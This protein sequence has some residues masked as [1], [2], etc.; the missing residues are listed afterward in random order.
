MESKFKDSNK[1]IND[2]KKVL[3]SILSL[4]LAVL[5]FSGQAFAY[6]GAAALINT[7]EELNAVVDFD[8]AEIY[9]AFDEVND[10]V[11]TIEQ[12]ESI[13]YSALEANESD[14]INNVS[15]SAA[16]AMNANSADSPPFLS[17][18]LWGCLFNLL[19]MLIVGITTEF[20]SDQM[21]KSAW[22]CL[23]NTLL[24]SGGYISTY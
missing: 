10:L 20:D 16:I 14:L 9:A 21:R 3:Q 6:T 5:L 22:G 18:F 13:T 23:I 8:E 7:D 19:G 12:D 17:A 4:V 2:M 24:T 15:S 1:Y 11:A